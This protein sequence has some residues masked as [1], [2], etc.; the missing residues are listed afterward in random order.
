MVIERKLLTKMY[1]FRLY[2][3]GKI[4]P[5]KIDKVE[6][7]LMEYVRIKLSFS[8]ISLP[9]IFS[10]QVNCIYFIEKSTIDSKINHVS[11]SPR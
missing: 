1:I 3:P 8:L 2:N 10:L 9:H 11:D 5:I 7:Q 4:K 6:R